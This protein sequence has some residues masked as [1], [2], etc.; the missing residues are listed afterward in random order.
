VKRRRRT[1]EDNNAKNPHTHTHSNRM[2]RHLHASLGSVRRFGALGDPIGTPRGIPGVRCSCF[3]GGGT[4]GGGGV[5]TIRA[6]HGTA[7][8]PLVSV[9]LL[10]PPNAGKSTLFNRL[11][12]ES[13][14]SASIKHIR[15]KNKKISGRL[16]RSANVRGQPFQHVRGT[17]I[18][19]SVPGTTRDVNVCRGRVA[20]IDFDLVDT[21][22]I[23]VSS[24]SKMEQEVWMRDALRQTTIAAQRSD[25]VFLM[26]DGQLPRLTSDVHE[27]AAQL[28]RLPTGSSSDRS[29]SSESRIVRV[30]VNKMEAMSVG[31]Y[32]D[33]LEEAEA[34]GFGEPIPISALHGEGMAEIA[35]VI[36]EATVAKAKRRGLGGGDFDE[37]LA[38]SESSQSSPPADETAMLPTDPSAPLV[39]AILGRVNV[40]KSTL[41]NQLVELGSGVKDERRQHDSSIGES[42][43]R[44]GEEAT[45]ESVG[46]LRRVMTGPTPGLTRDSIRLSFEWQPNKTIEVIDTAGIRKAL[47]KKQSR[48]G[49]STTSGSWFPSLWSPSPSPSPSASASSAPAMQHPDIESVAVL[50]AF[51]ACKTA[52]VVALVID[53]GARTL[54]RS[55]LAMCD[56]ILKEGRA[57]VVVANK[58]D[59]VVEPGYSMEQFASDV[60]DQLEARFPLLRKTPVVPMSA[61]SGANVSELLPVVW[62]ARERWQQRIPTP[63][64][65]RWIREVQALHPPPSASSSKSSSSTKAF[66]KKGKTPATPT[67]S[68]APKAKAKIKYMLQMRWRPPTFL[69]YCNS[70][71]L[72]DSHLRFLTRH[73]QDT[74]QFFG[75]PVR[76][77]VKRS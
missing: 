52:H 37:A 28:R 21:A 8:P 55:E 71:R 38:D 47:K 36:Q 70:D 18:V 68:S 25:V 22:G 4:G 44:H 72:P 32:P 7:T 24:S 19:S 12:S 57:L 53:A 61:L 29:S 20:G 50:E 66:K 42:N 62:T 67:A 26:V 9:A 33:V 58:M 54:L 56:A 2:W 39:L 3:W 73:F 5:V 40:G 64:L 34:L 46:G 76:L 74:F 13:A 17:A 27:T 51:H 11:A 31:E 23:D 77:S 10:G 41:V 75:M 30:L 1:V 49:E 15:S 43:D 69:L 48:E 63:R 59:L 65:N 16:A 45:G 35:S 6:L 60:S 14:V